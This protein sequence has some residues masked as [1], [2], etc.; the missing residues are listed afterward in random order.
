MRLRRRRQRP[1]EV[2][3]CPDCGTRAEGSGAEGLWPPKGWQLAEA[4]S[5]LARCPAHV[6]PE[7]RDRHD[8]RLNRAEQLRRLGGGF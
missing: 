6:L 7:P 5:L 4:D 1:T 2:W 8:W 3:T